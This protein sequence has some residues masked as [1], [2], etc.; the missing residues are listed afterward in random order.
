[1]YAFVITEFI[2][3]FSNF[4]K[5]SSAKCRIHISIN[6]TKIQ[7]LYNQKAN[8]RYDGDKFFKLIKFKNVKA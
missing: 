5:F 2:S 3:N 6:I 4:I 7:I 1:M 8:L